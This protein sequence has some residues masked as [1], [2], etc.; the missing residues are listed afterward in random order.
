MTGPSQLPDSGQATPNM[1]VF[2]DFELFKSKLKTYLFRMA[3]THSNAVTHFPIVIVF[4]CNYIDFFFFVLM[5]ILLESTLV[6]LCVVK[7]SIN[8][9][10]FID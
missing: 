8:K 2:T 10:K 3:L 1:R 5:L 4:Y 9:I 6:A 7:G